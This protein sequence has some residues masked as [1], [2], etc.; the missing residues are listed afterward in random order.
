MLTT[1]N[2][3]D[4]KRD[5]HIG[6]TGM[7]APTAL[8]T[9]AQPWELR[10]VPRDAWRRANQMLRERPLSTVG[11]VALLGVTAGYFLSRRD[12]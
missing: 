12:R 7:S 2:A 5:L 8:A 4:S 11:L 6:G 3:N 9:M 10:V 1:R